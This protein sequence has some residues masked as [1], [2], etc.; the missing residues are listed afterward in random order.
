MSRYIHQVNAIRAR[1]HGVMCE[2][3]EYETTY[4]SIKQDHWRG[5]S[6]GVKAINKARQI[7]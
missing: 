1:R 3:G 5:G 7:H 2:G 6:K 4:V